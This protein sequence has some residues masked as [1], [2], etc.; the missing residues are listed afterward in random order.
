MSE[1][2]A[3]KPAR[4]FIVCSKYSLLCLRLRIPYVIIVS[5]DPHVPREVFF[6]QDDF[7]RRCQELVMAGELSPDLVTGY[8][9]ADMC[10]TWETLTHQINAVV[11]DLANFVIEPHYQER[12]GELLSISIFVGYQVKPKSFADYFRILSVDRD[13][14]L[15]A[16]LRCALLQDLLRVMRSGTLPHFPL[17]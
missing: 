2:T 16:D 1:T 14:A 15:T 4:G 13:W 6:T 17:S 5:E 8:S 11:P 3:R 9:G 10:P 7:R 12:N